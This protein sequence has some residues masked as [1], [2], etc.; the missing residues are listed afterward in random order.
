MFSA[1]EAI[2]RSRSRESPKSSPAA[3]TSSSSTQ[4]STSMCRNSTK[5]NS[6]IRVSASSTKVRA[7]RS[8]AIGVTPDEHSENHHD[9]ASSCGALGIKPSSTGDDVGRQLSQRTPLGER[10]RPQP[11][12][13]LLKSNTELNRNHSGR[14]V[15]F[16]A[17]V[18]HPINYRVAVREVD[19]GLLVQQQ[20]QG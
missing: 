7:N 5:S 9:R 19:A 17:A 16:G 3:D 20:P 15:D 14:L 1:E 11:A 4:R 13:R 18:E 2:T 10:S 6:S 8:S 12:K